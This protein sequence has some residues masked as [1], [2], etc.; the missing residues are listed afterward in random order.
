[1]KDDRYDVLTVV[2]RLIILS[3]RGEE[4][5]VRKI[6]GRD[7]IY[8]VKVSKTEY[9]LAMRLGLSI[10]QFVKEYVDSIAKKRRWNWWF[11]K[12]RQIAKNSQT[13]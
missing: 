2:M 9:M 5:N 8:P 12:T 6:R 7:A 11:A 13:N 1:M 3:D 10:E 4:M